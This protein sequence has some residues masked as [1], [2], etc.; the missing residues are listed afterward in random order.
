LTGSVL[1]AIALVMPGI[2]PIVTAGPLAAEF[3]EAAGHIAG[4]LASVLRSAGLSQEQA[5]ALQRE[6]ANG[7]VLFGVHVAP[8][9]VERVREGLSA[10]GGTHLA[11]VTWPPA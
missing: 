4:S 2:G 7:S 8:A 1:A 5:D 11:V 3:G 9:D 6:V 10:A